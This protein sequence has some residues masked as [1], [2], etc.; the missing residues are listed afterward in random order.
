MR[1]LWWSRHLHSH[2]H[3]M[4]EAFNVKKPS[5]VP[6]LVLGAMDPHVLDSGFLAGLLHFIVLTL[7]LLP[8]ADPVEVEDY[9]HPCSLVCVSHFPYIVIVFLCSF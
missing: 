2:L 5:I 9:L 7:Q 1:H 8:A 6:L 3:E 4:I